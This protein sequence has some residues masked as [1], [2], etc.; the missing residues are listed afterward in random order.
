MKKRSDLPHTADGLL[1]QLIGLGDRSFR[2][3]YYPQLQDRLEQLERFR[4]LLDRIG[5]IILLADLSSLRLIDANA[6]ACRHLGYRREQLLAMNLDEVIEMEALNWR[7]HELDGTVLE[8]VLRCAN[9]GEVPV[10]VTLSMDRFNTGIYVATV[11]RNISERLRAE[12]ALRASDRLKTEFVSTAAHEFRTPLTTIQ[13]FSQLLLQDETLCE[14]ERRELL[15]YILQKTQALG[16]I[17]ADLL[18]ITRI[19]TGQAL[20]LDRFPCMAAQ[21]FEPLQLLLRSFPDCGRF[22]LAIED[23]DCQLQ[24]DRHR[25]SQVTENLL[26]NAVKYSPPGSPIS[27]EGR[28]RNGEYE[29][30]IAD[31]GIGMTEQQVARV[32]DK[33]Y[34]G[35]FSNTA[36]G[37]IG[38]GMSVVKNIVEAHGGRIWVVSTPGLGTT[39]RL[40]LPVER[41]PAGG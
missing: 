12:E 40:R 17:V 27:I 18:D 1:E 36:A 21:L 31:Q 32:F 35:N 3:N 41:A 6:S 13:G 28:V 34:R 11:A 23:G 24:I 22:Q 7:E 30:T 25:F 37:G 2:K 38:L 9:G 10:E 19:E 15:T 8:T 5:D 39:V 20:P 16:R 26:D 29:I 14:T 4:A 33:F